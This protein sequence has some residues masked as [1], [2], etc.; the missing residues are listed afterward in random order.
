MMQIGG[1]IGLG[2]S[3][4]FGGSE[5]DKE[6]WA[7]TEIAFFQHYNPLGII[8]NSIPQVLFIYFII[9]R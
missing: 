9:I 6:K 1:V 3:F 5:N 4:H 2:L 7:P 8:K